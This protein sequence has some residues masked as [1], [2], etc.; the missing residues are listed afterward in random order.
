MYLVHF[1]SRDL[2]R[3][4]RQG[5]FWHIFFSSGAVIISQ[6]EKDTWTTHLPVAL[7]ADISS[8][9]PIK[10]IHQVLG[11]SVSPYPIEV[12]KVMITSAWRPNICIT[13]RYR[14]AG[15][16]IFLSG[17]AA[18]QNIPTGGYGMNTALGDSFDIGW[19]LS[20]IIKGY[21]GSYLL[22][23]YE[24]E[25]RPVAVRNIGRSGDHSSVHA[26]YIQWVL[27]EGKEK[28]IAPTEG[29]KELRKRI[30]DHV[31]LHDGENKDHGIEMGY[32]YN[33]SP[34]VVLTD[35]RS[36]E[37][38]WNTKDYIPSTWPGAR[39]PHVFLRD[40]KTSIYDHFG[41]EYTFIDFTPNATLAAHCTAL[42]QRLGIPIKVVH[43][44]DEP[45]VHSV[46]GKR[47]AYLIRP[48]DHVAWRAAAAKLNDTIEQDSIEDVLLI[49][50][51]QKSAISDEKIKAQNER[52]MQL[53]EKNGFNATVGNMD[54]DQ[55]KMLAAFQT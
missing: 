6:D 48:D 29:G 35:A 39:A 42:C 43:L 16:R 3:L 33:D 4:Q 2:S 13:D 21:A 41:P 54:H 17:D 40:G 14:S 36:D 10:A 11:G 47:D 18:H 20:A 15:G 25:R 44:S 26:T 37:P 22:D 27:S 5:Q 45:H 1:K 51:G 38:E 50:T 19:K 34:V 9:D 12:D 24:V 7:D 8:I 52:V 30:A 49:A 55:V 46:W 31:E 28:V 32:R 53:V 23:S